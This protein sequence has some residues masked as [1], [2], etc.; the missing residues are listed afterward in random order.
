M[1]AL[2]SSDTAPR[3][4]RNLTEMRD[5]VRGDLGLRDSSLVTDQDLEDWLNEAS[6]RIA[7]YTRWYRISDIVG[8]VS[9]TKE[10]QLPIPTAGRCLSIEEIIHDTLPLTLVTL[11][12]LQAL[13]PNYRNDGNGTPYL[14]YLRGSSGFGLH[15]TPNTT[16]ASILTVIFVAKPPRVTAP[17]DSFYVPHSAEDAL[18]VYA[19]KLASE[20]DLYGEGAKR[21]QL[22]AAEW[23]RLLVEI[24]SQV[25]SAADRNVTVVGEEG[26]YRGDVA[27]P[28]IPWALVPP[29]VP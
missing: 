10:Y 5:R 21:A 28:R 13:H 8:T 16:S 2:L 9:G 4:T 24:K 14:Y 12:Q 19:K 6:D 29:P 27:M 26:A 15:Y 22:Y 17:T 25:W 1:P 3:S 23:E 20:K 7:R 18:I 11:P